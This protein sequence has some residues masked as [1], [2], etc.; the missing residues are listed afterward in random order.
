MRS[1]YILLQKVF[2]VF[3]WKNE[4]PNPVSVWKSRARRGQRAAVSVLRVVRATAR[5]PCG[6]CPC[7]PAPGSTS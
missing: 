2:E 1:N 7:A 4:S 6:G 5:S 3:L